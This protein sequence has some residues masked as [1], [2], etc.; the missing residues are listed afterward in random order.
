MKK[1]IGIIVLILAISLIIYFLLFD[2]KEIY[3]DNIRISSAENVHKVY[4]MREIDS[5]SARMNFRFTYK[6][7]VTH[8]H[9][10][11]LR[12]PIKMEKPVI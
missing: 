4:S 1:A 10:D 5:I 3:P 11:S 6:N 7:A 9:N 2:R 8:L 12:T